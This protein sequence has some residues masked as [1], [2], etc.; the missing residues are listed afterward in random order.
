LVEASP[1]EALQLGLLVD[2]SPQLRG[3]PRPGLQV[4]SRS[5]RSCCVVWCIDNVCTKL[6]F[7]RGFP[8]LSPHFAPRGGSTSE[9]RLLFAPGAEWAGVTQQPRRGR[10]PEPAAAKLHTFG[11]LKLKAAGDSADIG[12]IQLQVVIGSTPA[13][14]RVGCDFTEK[15]VQSYDLEVDW[16]KHLEGDNSLLTLRMDFSW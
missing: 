16:R 5:H 3:T 9:L 6:R 4:V 14:Q 15:S 11:A 1:A 12:A 2:E 8:I 7:S 10:R 13:G